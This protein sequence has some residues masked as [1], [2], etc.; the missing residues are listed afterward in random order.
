MM[1]TETKNAFFFCENSVSIGIMKDLQRPA[2][3][4]ENI[5]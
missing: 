1:H 5:L 2:D 3:R 4:E